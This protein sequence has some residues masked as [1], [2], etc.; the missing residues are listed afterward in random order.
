M[1]SELHPRFPIVVADKDHLDEGFSGKILPAMFCFD[2][3]R[4]LKKFYSGEHT[5]EIDEH[6]LEEFIS[7]SNTP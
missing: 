6:L 1:V 5:L 2:E 4:V 3:F 7:S